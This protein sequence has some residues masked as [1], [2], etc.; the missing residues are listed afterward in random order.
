MLDALNAKRAL[1]EVEEKELYVKIE[2]LEEQIKR[3][4]G[5]IGL[6]DEMIAE[7]TSETVEAVSD[8]PINSGI[9]SGF[10]L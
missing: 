1:L 5:K 10:I 8:S 9:N 2:A 7:E 6:V 3:V 4:Q